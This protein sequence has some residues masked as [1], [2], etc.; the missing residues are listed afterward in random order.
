MGVV[1]GLL[2]AGS[3]SSSISTTSILAA[4]AGS[5]GGTGSVG[6]SG[7]AG[8]AAPKFAFAGPAI[9]SST[10]VIVSLSCEGAAGTACSGR[11]QLTTVEK[12][13]GSKVSG[14]SARK[15]KS[16]SKRVVVAEATFTLAAGYTHT[17]GPP[18]NATGERLLKRFGNL[19]VTLTITLLNTNPP[20]AIKT[21]A[22]IKQ[23]HKPRKHR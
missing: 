2:A 1:L 18:L 20:T 3:G 9:A 12:L 22:T 7:G 16:R 11:E 14:L 13:V 5:S 21:K 23:K 19:P 4:P 15:K 10:G 6:S 8:S 17:I